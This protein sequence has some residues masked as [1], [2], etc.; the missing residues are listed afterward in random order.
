MNAF[1]TKAAVISVALL[2]GA[3]EQGASTKAAPADPSTRMDG[4][5]IAAAFT[6]KTFRSDKNWTWTFNANGT[7][8]SV[9][10]DNSWSTKG[11]WEV[12][13]DQLCRASD[14]K[15]ER[16]SYIHLSDGVFDFTKQGSDA[17]E[18]WNLTAI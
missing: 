16:C 9:A 6:G 15:A 17:M 2:I 7:Q 1:S 12:R 5:A 10:A 3:C 4:A 8:S 11:V 13:G 14:G 18:G